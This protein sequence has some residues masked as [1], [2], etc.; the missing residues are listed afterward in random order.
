MVVAISGSPSRALAQQNV[1]Y[2]VGEVEL[3]DAPGMGVLATT[4]GFQLPA[5]QGTGSVSGTVLDVSG[6]TVAGARVTLAG[7]NGAGERVVT[8]DSKGEFSFGELPPGTFRVTVTSAGLET[9]VS[10]EIRL[11]A[12]QRYE[13][14]SIGL[15]IATT[16]TDVQVTVTQE[17]LAH[18]QLK[19]AESQ[20]VLGVLP[21]FYSSYVWKAAPMNPKQ[22][23]ELAFRATT[24]PVA[25]VTAGIV[26]GVEQSHN[27]FP[28]YGSGVEGYA[29]RYGAAYADV[30]IGRYIGSAVLPS[31]FRQD[32][33]YFYRGSGSVKS[34]AMYAIAAAFIC[35]GD[36][37]RWQPN[38]SHLLGNFA[39]AG[40]SNVYRA[41]EDRSASLTIRNG[42]II[43]GGNVASN[44][45]REFVLR[46]FTTNV[47]G[48]KK[49]KP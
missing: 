24:D 22:K 37:G 10:N 40:L 8:S 14:P 38:Y 29:K 39:A 23:F 43:T 7:Q 36:N 19:A 41:P 26:A 6:A 21:N 30:T 2:Q 42:F 1:S 11:A 15:P 12:G 45:V 25:F 27:T 47:A 33:R 4:G 49:G 35:R 28:G 44:L 5:A 13:L 3:P 17:E 16:S 9:F 32:P 34:R 48:Y 31:L 46:R 18:E 20:R